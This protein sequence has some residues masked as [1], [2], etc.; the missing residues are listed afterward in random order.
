MGEHR[1]ANA[2]GEGS[3][4]AAGAVEAETPTAPKVIEALKKQLKKVVCQK[5]CP[6]RTGYQCNAYDCRKPKAMK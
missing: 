1:S 4:G 5:A 6:S 2:E 3:A